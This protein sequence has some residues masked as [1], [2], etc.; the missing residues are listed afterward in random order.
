MSYGTVNGK[1]SDPEGSKARASALATRKSGTE[2]TRSTAPPWRQGNP[3]TGLPATGV[4]GARR[5]GRA[6]ML[7]YP[8]P[9]GVEPDAVFEKLVAVSVRSIEYQRTFSF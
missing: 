2:P 4:R 8:A 9:L 5:G 3:E 7:D 1:G 6:G